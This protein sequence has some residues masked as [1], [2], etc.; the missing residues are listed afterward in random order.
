MFGPCNNL[1][2]FMVTSVLFCIVRVTKV[3][4]LFVW[5]FESSDWGLHDTGDVVVATRANTSSPV[6]VCPIEWLF[7]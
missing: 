2:T 7:L 4:L 6:P 3:G 5:G 1:P